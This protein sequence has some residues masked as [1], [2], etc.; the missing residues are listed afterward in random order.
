MDPPVTGGGA[1]SAARSPRRELLESAE[2]LY[3]DL[4]FSAVTRW[5]AQHPGGKAIG[6]LPPWAPRELIHAAGM[7]PVGIFGGGEM[8][9]V[10]G[11]AYFQSYICH[12]P[13]STIELGLN[14]ALDVLDGMVFPSICDVVRNLSG[15]WQILFPDRYVRY[16]DMPQ[17]FD[18][19]IGGTFLLGELAAFRR[20]LERMSGRAVTDAA[21]AASIELYDENRR[22]IEELWRLRAREPWQVPTSEL[23]LMLR[24]GAVLPVEEHNDWLARYGSAVLRE[25]RRPMDMARVLV[26]GAFCEQPPLDL[27]RTLERSGCCIV[28]DDFL[29][30]SRW[31]TGDVAAPGDPLENLARAFLERSPSCASLY[32]ERG[33]KGK[34]LTRAAA[35]SGA[36][37][38]VFAAASFCDPALL[39]QPMALD[40][41]KAAGIPCTSF[42]YSESSGQFQVIREQAGTFADSIRLG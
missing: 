22:R 37:G 39:D 25:P 11:D 26:R 33:A 5:K 2:D 6:H 21:L 10:R 7:L 29:M 40:A 23:Y 17:N 12:L 28:D 3:R 1:S 13:R 36:E 15:M 4:T 9:V 38:V 14:G 20:D 27:I 41:A 8:E 24:A 18:P 42:Q 30:V 19:R 31:I 35:E 34:A 32:A 16:F